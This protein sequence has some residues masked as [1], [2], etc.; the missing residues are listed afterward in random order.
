MFLGVDIGTSA[1]KVVCSDGAAILAMASAPLSISSPRAGWSEQHPDNWWHATCAALSALGEKVRLTD[2]NAVGLSGQM[3]G[4]VL[5]DRARAVIRPAILWNDSR[6]TQECA[7][8]LRAVPK[9]GDVAGIPPL[10]GFTAPK[11]MWLAAHEPEAYARIAHVLLPKDYLGF[12]LHGAL[13]TDR[14]DAAGTLWLNQITRAW[15][16]EIVK[17]SGIS[18]DWLP[19]LHDGHDVVAT[20][21]SQSANETGLRPGIPVVAGGGD[22]ATGAISLG[23]TEPA[24]GFVSLGTSGQL[25]VSDRVY[26]PNPDKFVHAYAHTLPDRWFQMAAM[27]NGARPISW[28]GDQLGLTPAE[29][30]ALAESVEGSRVPTFLPYLT[31]ERSPHGDPHIRAG[32]FGLEDATT[33]AELCRAVVE[34]VAFCFADAADSF[35][36]GMEALP[37]LSAIGGGSRSDFLLSLISTAVG[38]PLVRPD[39]ADAGPA[40]GAAQLAACGAGA[41]GFSEFGAKRLNQKQFLPFKDPAFSR[42]LDR[43]RNLYAALRTLRT[44]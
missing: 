33:R 18:Q 39:G 15:D 21:T 16:A 14:S 5:L 2:I 41:L 37:E 3:H 1:V 44:F 43:F 4:A 26:R 20:V 38:K 27:L 17:A 32:F 23:A 10:P 6:A 22:A 34:A 11:L 19:D 42:R 30:M 7:A 12:R 29:V 28:I 36:D 13:A 9:I 31:G 25:F 24:R 40:F 35:G 8:L